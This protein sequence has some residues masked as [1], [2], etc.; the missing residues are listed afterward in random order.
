LARI[1]AIDYGRKRTGIA[2][3]DPFQIIATGLCTI[4]SSELFDWLKNYFAKEN[5]ETIVLG[6]PL[7]TSG[8]D[9]DITQAVRIIFKKLLK[10]F[11]DKH[12]ELIDERY[13]TSLALHAIREANLKKKLRRD[14][15][16]VDCI[17][18]TIILQNYLS[19]KN[20]QGN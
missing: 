17:S 20:V 16:L 6:Y 4:Y 13:T 18:A 3:T 11:P 9:T 1:L 14:K 19:K 5:V 15:N 10:N 2:V 8:E 7:T 12:I